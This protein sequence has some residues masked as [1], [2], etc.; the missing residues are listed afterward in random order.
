MENAAVYRRAL[1]PIMFALGLIGIVAA[2][3]GVL[4]TIGLSA[5]WW[6]WFA[7][8]GVAV[9]MAFGL[10]RRQAWRDQE[11]FWSRPTRRVAQ[12]VLTPLVAGAMLTLALR[13]D[14]TFLVGMW[15]LLYGCAL[16]ATGFFTVRGVDKL[17]WLFVLAGGAFLAMTWRSEYVLTASLAH[18]AMGVC[19][20]GFH[21]ACGFYLLI[22]KRS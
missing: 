22:T 1:A 3:A 11:P 14:A 16:R 2:G 13:Y 12:A 19:F 8:A 4:F 20:G 6:Y 7:V 17:G 21:L 9:G 10:A 5:F 18:A 15:L